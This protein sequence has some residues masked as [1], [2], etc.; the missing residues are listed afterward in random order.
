MLMTVVFPLPLGP[1]KPKVSPFSTRK[2]K[3]LTAVEWP[4]RLTKCSAEMAG[5]AGFWVASAIDSTSFFQFHV[6]SHSGQHMAAG[7]IDAN[8][9]AKNLVHAF[10][11]RLDVA[12]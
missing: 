4:K 3:S 10:L 6:G 9:H 1:R 8:L 7:I 5:A 12:R 2:L 11:A